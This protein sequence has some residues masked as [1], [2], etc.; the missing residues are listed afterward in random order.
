M[1]NVAGKQGSPEWRLGRMGIPTASRAEELVTPVRWEPTKNDRREAY[2]NELVAE[3]YAMLHTERLAADPQHRLEHIEQMLVR[4]VQTEAM[5]YGNTME[6][7]A[8]SAYEFLTDKKTREVGLVLNDGKSA[9]ASVDR[10]IIGSNVGL[11]IKC[12][13]SL[14]VYIGYC[15]EKSADKK[16]MPQLQWQMWVCGYEAIEIYA[17]YPGM[18]QSEPIRVERDES[19]IKTLS[20]VHAEFWGTLENRWAEFREKIQA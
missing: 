6:P 3:R 15:F 2:I 11:E 8:V 16:H 17:F 7:K 18:T 5:I 14:G 10:E 19:K 1:I 13:F 9:G 12:P 20:E 4:G